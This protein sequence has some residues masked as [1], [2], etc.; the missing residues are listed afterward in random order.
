MSISEAKWTCAFR[1]CFVDHFFLT[2]DFRQVSHIPC[3]RLPFAAGIFM[4]WSTGMKLCNKL[5][6]CSELSSF[7][8]IWPSWWFGKD[9]PI[10]SLVDSQTSKTHASFDLI[11][12][13][14][15]A[16]EIGVSSFLRTFLMIS[17]SSL[18][19]GSMKKF[20]LI[21]RHYRVSVFHVTTFTSPS[22]G[23]FF[24]IL[25]RALAIN[26]LAWMSLAV[27]SVS[28]GTTYIRLEVSLLKEKTEWNLSK[29]QTN[30]LIHL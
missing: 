23:H 30:L 24:P 21:F 1:H 16:G 9:S 11:S 29:N 5:Y 6:C 10:R 12:L 15:M 22:T 2:F 20:L 25:S 28:P 19:S 13:Q 8:A 3:P 7:P 14:G 17:L 18:S 26:D 4:A 27:L